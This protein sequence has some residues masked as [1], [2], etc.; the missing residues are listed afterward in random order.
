MKNAFHAVAD[1]DCEV[2]C[3]SSSGHPQPG[4]RCDRF[5]QRVPQSQMKHIYSSCDVFL[6]LS[7]VEC[8]FLPPLEMMACGQG[9]CVLGEV[10]GIDEYVVDQHN[11][12]VVKQGDVDAARRAV[13][14]LI[15]DVNLRQRLIDGGLA[16]ASQFEWDAMTTRLQKVLNHAM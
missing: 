6:K 10:T 8:F 13:Q 3:V 14:R 12:L 2:W 4:W 15:D 11:A 7:E 5:F 9:A 16:T 1:L